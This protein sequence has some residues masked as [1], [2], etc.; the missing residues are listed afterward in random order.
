MISL[1]KYVSSYSLCFISFYDIVTQYHIFLN[2]DRL[3]PIILNDVELFK[4]QLRGVLCE[5][6]IIEEKFTVTNGYLDDLFS[7]AHRKP[8]NNS[9]DAREK[10]MELFCD[11]V[12]DRFYSFLDD[13]QLISDN[14]SNLHTNVK[15]LNLAL[16]ELTKKFRDCMK[17][18]VDETSLWNPVDP[19]ELTN[20]VLKAHAETRKTSVFPTV[21]Q[22]KLID[23]KS[24][25]T[26]S[27]SA[28]YS[29]KDS[30]DMDVD[31]VDDGNNDAHN[32]NDDAV[33]NEIHEDDDSSHETSAYDT[34]SYNTVKIP[35]LNNLSLTQQQTQRTLDEYFSLCSTKKK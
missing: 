14:A 19:I 17:P 28:D 33:D 4:T 18:A 6:G 27:D 24:L 34:I 16:F 10:T 13:L 29:E 2:M 30:C 11:M 7:L 9:E 26:E 35:D 22:M 12:D 21:E 32:Q 20:R 15:H 23:M 5:L 3:P 1:L 25:D 8:L 31:K